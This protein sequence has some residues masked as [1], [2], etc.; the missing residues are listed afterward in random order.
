MM[1]TPA[2][3]NY[4]AH[5]GLA[6]VASYMV[7][8]LAHLNGD[9]LGLNPLNGVSIEKISALPSFRRPLNLALSRHLGL[10]DLLINP[11]LAQELSAETDI[12]LAVQFLQFDLPKVIEISKYCA[13]AQLFPQIRNCVLKSHRQKTEEILGTGAFVTALREV[14]VFFPNLP[15]RSQKVWIETALREGPEAENP[16]SATAQSTGQNAPHALILE[17]LKTLMAFIRTADRTLATLFAM[18][19]PALVSRQLND[20]EK[21]SNPQSAEL[22]TLLARRGIA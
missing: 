8:P 4:E 7:R 15:E 21:I 13:A 5:S 17:G 2:P 11:D 22:K 12:R 10:A 6:L 19:F 18:R 9:H 1:G 14:P 3:A 20:A 16:D